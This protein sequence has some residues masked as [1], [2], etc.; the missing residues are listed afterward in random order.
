LLFALSRIPPRYLPENFKDPAPILAALLIG[1]AAAGLTAPRR[2]GRLSSAFFEG[3][4]YAYTHVISLIVVA[5]VFA[6]GVQQ[7]GLI[8]VL[9]AKLRLW[10]ALATLACVALPWALAFVSG[11]GIAPTVAIMTFFVPVAGDLGID[12]VR[13]GA[14]AAMGAHFGRTMSPAAAVVAMSAQLSDAPPEELIKG[15]APALLAGGVVLIA[16]VMLGLV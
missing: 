4:G 11:T 3:A 8:A 10:P 1:V 13:L 15:V 16:G 9:T 7:S 12:P 14:L 5:T 2:A 6:D